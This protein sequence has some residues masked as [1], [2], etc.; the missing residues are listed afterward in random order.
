MTDGDKASAAFDP[1]SDAK[2]QSLAPAEMITCDECLRANPPTRAKCLYCAAILPATTNTRNSQSPVQ[3][4]AESPGSTAVNSGF[5]VVLAPA[6]IKVLT[7]SSLVEAAATL[8]LKTSEVQIAVGPGRPVPLA[9]AATIEQATTIAGRLV[10]LGIGLDIFREDTLKLDLPMTRIRAL[11][12]TNEGVAA[13]PL[14]GTGTSLKWDDLILI[15]AGRWLVKRVEVE[16]RRRR[17]STKPLASRELFSDEPL[18]D[19]YTRSDEAGFRV[20]SSSFDFSCL[21]TEKSVTAFE[22]FTKLLNLLGRRAPKVEVDE[23][24]HSIRAVLGS[25]WPLEPQMSKGER[26]RSG[27]GKVDVSTVTT[28]DNETQF[29]CYSRLRQFVKLRELENDK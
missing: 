21:G 23:T 22:N 26:R 15:V 11:E 5:L 1:I 29:N 6:Q 2:P 7:G 27:T 24:Y 8:G 20:Y 25:I 28:V 3:P 10:P 9:R 17:S 16:E 13:T 19:L 4:V 14:R 12:F 18:M